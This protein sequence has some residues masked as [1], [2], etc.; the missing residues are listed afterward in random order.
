MGQSYQEDVGQPDALAA[1]HS[2]AGVYF[3]VCH[4][5]LHPAGFRSPSSGGRV[6]A[7]TPVVSRKQPE[8]KTVSLACS[9]LLLIWGFASGSSNTDKLVLIGSNDSESCFMI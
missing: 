8:V 7:S 4:P 5:D 9:L 3:A 2:S 6:L 1:H